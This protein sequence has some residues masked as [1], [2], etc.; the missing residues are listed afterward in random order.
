ME[1]IFKK[2]R[3][4]GSFIWINTTPYVMSEQQQFGVT[5]VKQL[6]ILF[7]VNLQGSDD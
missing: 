7:D 1:I 3:G 4:G 2:D 6:V 5:D